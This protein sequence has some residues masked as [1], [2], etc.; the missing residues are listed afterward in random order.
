[1]TM[2][3]LHGLEVFGYHGV[4]EHEKRDG[5]PFLYDLELDVG[6]AGASDRIEDAVDYRD[7]AAVVRELSNAR[8]F[9]LL[10]ALAAAVADALLE[11][12]PQVAG[13]SVR[14]RKTQLRLPVE[15]SAATV[16]RSAPHR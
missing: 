11:R 10:E 1:M 14:V 5:Q 4:N 15:W 2:V 7:V 3:E 8:R 16:R 9:D 6:D 12:F 13:V